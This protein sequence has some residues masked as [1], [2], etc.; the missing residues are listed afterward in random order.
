VAATHRVA[1]LDLDAAAVEQAAA[2][3]GDAVWATCDITQP[4][5]IAAAIEHVVDACGGIDGCISNAG[6]SP[7]PGRC[8]TSIPV[9]SP[10][11][12]TST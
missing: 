3:L 7:P 8:A 1:L 10:R 9:S 5:S 11:S 2:R 12:S 4:E 6:A